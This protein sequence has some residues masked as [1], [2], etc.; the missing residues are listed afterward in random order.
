LGACAAPEKWNNMHDSSYLNFVMN[1]RNK[2]KRRAK[3]KDAAN[4]FKE[5]LALA[6]EMGKDPSSVMLRYYT[7]EEVTANVKENP[8]WLPYRE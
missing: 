2:L 4:A 5:I 7:K 1:K 8:N 6:N 3:S